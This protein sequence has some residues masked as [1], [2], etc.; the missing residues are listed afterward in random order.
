M[1]PELEICGSEVYQL[2]GR[3]A[4]G[5]SKLPRPG[6][7]IAAKLGTQLMSEPL[8]LVV[9]LAV[10][11]NTLAGKPTCSIIQP[12]HFH[13][14][15][16]LYYNAVTQTQKCQLHKTDKKSCR[17]FLIYTRESVKCDIFNIF[18]SPGF[19]LVT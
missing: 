11:R 2:T 18:L 1:S 9:R 8:Y 6:R 3:A 7:P 10:I 13:S 19:F 5:G 17:L 15:I 12:N 4:Q 16:V 14:P